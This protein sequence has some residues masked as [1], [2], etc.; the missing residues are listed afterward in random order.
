MQSLVEEANSSPLDSRVGKSKKRFWK[1]RRAWVAAAFIV[2]L[3]GLL[4]LARSRLYFSHQD[5]EYLAKLRRWQHETANP[6]DV[7]PSI[8]AH[9][10][11]KVGVSEDERAIGNTASAIERGVESGSDWIEIDI[12][13]TEDGILVVFH[14]EEIDRKTNGQGK[15]AETPWADLQK[16]DVEGVDQGTEKIL[17]LDE[18]FERF[19]PELRRQW[20][21]DIKGEGISAEVLNWL[22]ERKQLKEQ[23]RVILFGSHKILE[24]YKD[25]GYTLGYTE[26]WKGLANRLQVLFTPSVIVARCDRL[27][28]KYLILPV[29]LSH[30][31][32]VDAA[33]EKGFEV[34]I[35]G[36]DDTRDLEHAAA[37]GIS[38]V[39][40]Y[41]PEDVVGHFDGRPLKMP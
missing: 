41:E 16:V 24:D 28:C 26:T 31:S 17:T 15:V 20:I 2:L 35:S 25:S 5:Y 38:G 19:D 14:D 34:W 32:L 10:G 18:V 22:G 29:M 33:R 40:V 27:S 37:R 8:I 12:L 6:T 11:A 21:L 23:D 13:M 36:T 30:Q 1:R 3:S 7:R 4:W 39:I 9:R